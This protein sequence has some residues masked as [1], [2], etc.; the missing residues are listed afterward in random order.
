M[1]NDLIV[2]FVNFNFVFCFV[3]YSTNYMYIFLNSFALI[4]SLQTFVCIEKL[5]K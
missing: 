4:I 3:P 2:N 1:D 5:Y